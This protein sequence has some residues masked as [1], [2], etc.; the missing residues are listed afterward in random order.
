MVTIFENDTNGH[1]CSFR[2]NRKP[3]DTRP[4]HTRYRF[5]TAT[6]RTISTTAYHFFRTTGRFANLAKMPFPLLIQNIY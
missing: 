5:A 4:R 6:Y 2:A 1:L 3:R